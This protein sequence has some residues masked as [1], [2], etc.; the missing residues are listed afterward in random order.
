MK[1]LTQICRE[2]FAKALTISPARRPRLKLVSVCLG[3]RINRELVCLGKRINR[4][5]LWAMLALFACAQAQAAQYPEDGWWY[6]PAQSGRGF[7]VE[8][9]G[10]IMFIGSFVYAANGRPEWVVMQGNYSPNDAVVGQIGSTALTSYATANGQCIGC[11]FVAPTV[12]LSS[13]NPAS[14]T[15]KSNQTATLVWPGE[16]INLQRQFWAWRDSVDQLDGNWMLTSVTNGVP[17]TQIVKITANTSSSVRTANITTLS[18]G[19]AVGSLALSNNVLSLQLVGNT[20]TLPV[21]APEATRFYAGTSG[22][23]ALQVVGLRLSDTPFAATTPTTSPPNILFVIADD[24]GLD[25]SPCHPSVGTLKPTMPNLSGLCQRGLVFDQAW[26]HPT[27]TPTRASMLSGKYGI[28]SNVMAVDEILTNTDTLLS[29]LQQGSNPYS[30][31]VIGKWHVSG[32]NAA[33]NS[34]A[35]F[36]A[37][38]FAGF[39]TGALT[40]YSNWRITVNG[41]ASTT[42]NYATTELTDKAISWIG[43]RQQ[44]W[45]LWLAYNAPHTPFHTPPANLYTQPGLQNGTASDNSS[46]YFAAAEALDAELGRLMASIPAATLAN[47]T[48]VFMGDNGSPTQVAQSPYSSSRA[49]DTLYQGGINVP[50]VFSGAGVTRAGQREAA[51]VNSSD[52]N[53]IANG[54][55]AAH[56]LVI[57]GLLAKRTQFQL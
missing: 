35:A 15:F 16:T 5:L 29:R 8:R 44:P 17:T 50:L 43:A 28:H 11:A 42:T 21:L 40:D 34:P 37:T 47:T 36:G 30:V 33:A 49:K 9:Q 46:K 6:N 24:F 10:N 45:F 20:Q 26:A 14:I 54:I 57:Q 55:S 48:I 52:T 1:A 41:A 23:N 31:A 22:A 2:Y 7:L 32:S 53:L 3:K 38:Y 25:T 39:L 51:L 4:S 18:S 56:D 13:Q 12:T 19:A 27:C